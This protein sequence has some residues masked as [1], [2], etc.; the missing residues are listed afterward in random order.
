M[1]TQ[2]KLPVI[3]TAGEL[4]RILQVPNPR[5]RTGLRN[6]CM[7]RLAANTGIKPSELVSIRLHDI[8]W[9]SGQ[10]IVRNS[11]DQ[12]DRV[13]WLLEEDLD[14]LRKWRLARPEAEI[15]HLFITFNGTPVNHRY[16]RQL[17]VQS[18][19]RAGVKK[20]ISTYTL[21]HTFGADLYRN[22][23][24]LDLVKKALGFQTL[25]PAKVYARIV[26][27]EEAGKGIVVA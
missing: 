19:R 25:E 11:D 3:L 4:E 13:L 14:L 9:I 12:P 1:E 20:K 17:V 23:R 24:N 16:I 21:R 7:L 5:S 18:A 22:T 8:N 15:P 2:E 26:E 27:A 6:L 10:L